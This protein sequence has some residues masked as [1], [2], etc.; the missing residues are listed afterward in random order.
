M[1]GGVK[2]GDVQSLVDSL[3]RR[4]Q[5]WFWY[6]SK[7]LITWH[8]LAFS[9]LIH[10]RS[11]PSS[12]SSCCMG[13][14]KGLPPFALILEINNPNKIKCFNFK[15]AST[16]AEFSCRCQDWDQVKDCAL[17]VLASMWQSAGLLR[18]DSLRPHK[19]SRLILDLFRFHVCHRCCDCIGQSRFNV[20][21][22]Y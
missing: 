14:L 7:S 12:A 11:K 1:T 21:I 17:P 10:H 3:K 20:Y 4:N 15:A 16:P 13:T 2:A 9:F 8:S 6:C 5:V 22:L 18:A 19:K